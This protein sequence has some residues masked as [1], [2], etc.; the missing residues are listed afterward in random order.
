MEKQV[1]IGLK[2]L[3]EESLQEL[4]QYMENAKTRQDS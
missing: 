3:N 1:S 2:E 4:V